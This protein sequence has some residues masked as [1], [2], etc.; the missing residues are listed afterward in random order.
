[1]FLDD[2][3]LLLQLLSFQTPAVESGVKHAQLFVGRNSLL[4][5]VYH[6]KSD[7]CL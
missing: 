5:Y 2:M 6:M 3:Y 7:K 1:M 4:A